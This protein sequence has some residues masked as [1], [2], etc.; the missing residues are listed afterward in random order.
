MSHR[1]IFVCLHGSAKSLIAAEYLK[2]FAAERGV[3]VETLSAGVEPDDAIPTR[4]VEGL[5]A[6][7]IDVRDRQPIAVS[8][9]ILRDADHIVSFGCDLTSL[10]PGDIP[11]HDWSDVPAV[12]DGFDTARHV[13]QERLSGLLDQMARVETR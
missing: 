8:K 5:M 12:S 11:L 9:D 7:G 1:I 10:A 6:E 13:I 2:R 4:V 3:T